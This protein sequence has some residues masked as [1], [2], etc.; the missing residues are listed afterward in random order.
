[1]KRCKLPL[2]TR[3]SFYNDSLRVYHVAGAALGMGDTSVNKTTPARW[4]DIPGRETGK[5]V[6]VR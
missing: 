1:M 2:G 6:Y 4:P 3:D 5:H